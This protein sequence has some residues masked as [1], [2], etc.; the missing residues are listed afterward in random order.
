V[1]SRAIGRVSD[2]GEK[3]RSALVCW[4]GKKEGTAAFSRG[5]PG[6]RGPSDH[7]MW[8]RGG[9]AGGCFGRRRG[10]GGGR[11]GLGGPGGACR[12]VGAEGLEGVR[13]PPPAA[14]VGPPAGALLLVDWLR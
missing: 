10:A 8:S 5:R 7:V 13:P 9:E 12:V 6:S 4:K 3:R 1:S 11:S 14:Y 2:L